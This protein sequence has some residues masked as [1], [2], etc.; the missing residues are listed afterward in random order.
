MPHPDTRLHVGQGTTR[1]PLTVFPVWTDAPTAPRRYVT[2]A[3]TAVDVAE[4]AGTPVVEELVVTNRSDRPVLLLAGELLEGGWQTRALAATTLLAPGQP[5]VQ[6]VVC[7]EQ[8]R[9]SGGTTHVRRA[10]RA[11]LGVLRGMSSQQQVWKR[12]RGYADVA[13]ESPTESLADRLDST[14]PRVRSLTRGLRPL[15][16]Q[17]GL[18]I[19]LAGQP[20]WLEVFDSSR[21]LAAHWPALLHAATLDCLGRP[22]VRTPAARAR[23]FAQQAEIARL[24]PAGPAGLGTRLR[25]GRSTHVDAVRW[26]DRIIHLSAIAQEA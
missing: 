19:G 22:E 9:W 4:R 11:P 24:S 23:S 5:T 10:R 17:R 13:G 6:P 21:S 2:G 3:A 7:V 25:G 14:A 26:N 16:G 18:L 1:G 20:V 8:G 12:A 15:A